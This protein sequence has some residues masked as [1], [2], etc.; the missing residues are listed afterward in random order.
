MIY[1]RSVFNDS[2]HDVSIS[3]RALSPGHGVR[4]DKA[5]GNSENYCTLNCTFQNTARV[6]YIWDHD[7]LLNFSDKDLNDGYLYKIDYPLLLFS[8]L[9]RLVIADDGIVLINDSY[10]AIKLRSTGHLHKFYKMQIDDGN[11]IVRPS[12]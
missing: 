8:S 10:G 7:Y 9:F 3:G 5:I 2:R 4:I 6:I 11:W 12:E 1:L